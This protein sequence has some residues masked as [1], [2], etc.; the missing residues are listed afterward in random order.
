MHDNAYTLK[1]AWLYMVF[2]IIMLPGVLYSCKK[3]EDDTGNN[4][5]ERKKYAWA[6]GSTDSTGYG[7]ILFSA[8]GGTSWIRQGLGAPVLLNN[9]LC[10]IWAV[11]EDN[12]WVI[13]SASVARSTD[14]GQNWTGVQVP[15][16]PAATEFLSIS[17]VNKTQ[18]WISGNNGIIVKSTDNGQTW[19][20][21]NTAFP[22]QVFFQGIWAMNSQ[23]VYAAGGLPTGSDVAG[24][25]GFTQDGGLN[26]DSIVPAH[27]Y[28]MHEWI[29]V[30]GSGSTIV[31]YGRQ[32]HYVFSKDGGGTWQ[33][34]SVPITGGIFGADINHLIMLNPQTW[35]GAFDLG[36]VFLTKDGGTTWVEQTTG[37]GSFYLM[38]IDAWDNQLALA[39]GSPA[40]HYNDCPIIQTKD[41]G[42]L[43][44]VKYLT[45]DASLSK[46]TFIKK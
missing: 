36:Q 12:I 42:I 46:I 43:W 19:T 5:P 24:F 21:Y 44:E 39:V 4:P 26:W 14:G 29:G 27:N 2:S 23:E 9:Q 37:Q 22:D 45:S 20:I 3:Q 7:L 25:I 30:C 28:N 1:K 16:L 31:V 15:G 18:V 6:C 32:A 33:N 34:D 13:G 41:G 38:G 11:D 10:D 40:S 35:W 8:D 17:V